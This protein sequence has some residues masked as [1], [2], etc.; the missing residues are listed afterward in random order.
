MRALEAVTSHPS[1]KRESRSCSRSAHN[2]A[3][4]RSPERNSWHRFGAT[5][6]GIRRLNADA[7]SWLA[8]D[9]DGFPPVPEEKGKMLKTDK[10]FS[11][12]GNSQAPLIPLLPPAVR[13]GWPT[14]QSALISRNKNQD[15]RRHSTGTKPKVRLTSTG[16]FGPTG[17]VERT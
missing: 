10:L 7:G 17:K 3:D 4:G 12:N 8:P 11:R 16:R 13:K 9:G 15:Q 5:N 2:W 1:R 6:S 14:P